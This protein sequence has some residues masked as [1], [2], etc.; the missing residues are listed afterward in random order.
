MVEYVGEASDVSRGMYMQEYRLEKDRRVQIGWDL[1][2][3]FAAWSTRITLLHLD[4]N[5]R[6]V[7]YARQA[8]TFITSHKEAPGG[9]IVRHTSLKG[10]KYETGLTKVVF[11]KPEPPQIIEWYEP[12]PEQPQPKVVTFA[13]SPELLVRLIGIAGEPEVTQQVPR[14]VHQLT[15]PASPEVIT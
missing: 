15:S 6:L 11:S 2:R 14:L 1:G 7:E 3:Y 12:K 9:D 8:D 13:G 4:R 5:Q 10:I